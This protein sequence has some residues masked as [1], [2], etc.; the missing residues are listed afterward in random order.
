V[1]SGNRFRKCETPERASPRAQSRASTGSCLF[2][3][4][5]L[6]VT[7]SGSH[8]SMPCLGSHATDPKSRALLR[9]LLFMYCGKNRFSHRRTKR[10][11]CHARRPVKRD[12]HS[13][14]I[15][16]NRRLAA[17]VG[18]HRSR[19]LAVGESRESENAPCREITFPS[20]N[21]VDYPPLN[22]YAFRGG[23]SMCKLDFR[24]IK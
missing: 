9:S 22:I 20:R 16:I 3:R 12:G 11:P 5:R 19:S 23:Q 1:G 4:R 24:P 10:G 15:L 2:P 13:G 7:K 18:L 14:Q 8:C 21:S 6:A 17:Y